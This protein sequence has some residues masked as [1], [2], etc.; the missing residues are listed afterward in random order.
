MVPKLQIRLG[1][2]TG[3]LIIVCKSIAASQRVCG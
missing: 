3:G 2:K 1:H